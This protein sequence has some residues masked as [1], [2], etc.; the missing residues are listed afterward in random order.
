MGTDT[1]EYAVMVF[2]LA[3][4]GM[5]V[6]IVL[7]FVSLSKRQPQADGTSKPSARDA[8]KA[9]VNAILELRRVVKGGNAAEIPAA[10]EKFR[11]DA[12]AGDLVEH[13]RKSEIVDAEDMLWVLAYL[14]RLDRGEGLQTVAKMS[15]G[16]PSYFRAD[17]ASRAMKRDD[18]YGQLDIC[19]KAIFFDGEKLLTMPWGRILTV[20]VDRESLIVHR[21]TGGEPYTFS[22]KSP[23]EAKLAQTVALAIQR[24]SVTAAPKSRRSP[25]AVSVALSAGPSAAPVALPTI[26]VGEKSGLCGFSIV[27]ESNYQGRLRIVCKTSGRSFTAAILAEPNNAYDPNAIRV[28][29]ESGD[30][31]GYL[32][33]EDAVRY[34]PAFDL[35]ARHGHMGSCQARLTGGEGNKRSFGVI[36]SLRESDDLVVALRDRF[37][38]GA[39]VAGD[40]SPF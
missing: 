15:D 24:Q 40:L 9:M 3:I 37:E 19:D 33:R 8:Q 29:A 23:Q 38:P 5:V 11:A 26:D 27:G 35:L 34:K 12:I 22:L 30:T 39:A 13:E 14:E 1:V 21:T 25:A 10:I 4:L 31:I 7:L 6:V 16:A 17:R 18:D 20:A 28:A 36:L 32:S 2:Q